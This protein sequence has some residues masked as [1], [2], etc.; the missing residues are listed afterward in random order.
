MRRC[1]APAL[2]K[3]EVRRSCVRV[4]ATRRKVGTSKRNALFALRAMRAAASVR[5]PRHR[6]MPCA[7]LCST[8]PLLYASKDLPAC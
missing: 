8:L 1:S 6:C 4:G 7:A 2:G 5:L 3:I